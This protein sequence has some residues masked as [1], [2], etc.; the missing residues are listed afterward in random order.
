MDE[1]ACHF[2]AHNRN[3]YPLVSLPP[4][5]GCNVLTSF[6]LSA[7]NMIHGITGNRP[8]SASA[9][10]ASWSAYNNNDCELYFPSGNGT[11]ETTAM[12]RR[13]CMEWAGGKQFV[14]ALMDMTRDSFFWMWEIGPASDGVVRLALWLYQPGLQKY[15]MPR[16]SVG[17]LAVAKDSFRV[18]R[19]FSMWKTGVGTTVLMAVQSKSSGIGRP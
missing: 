10:T 19:V 7:Y 11:A 18:G 2:Q 6:R 9:T 14:L 12:A 8:A 13:E 5:I 15:F 17:V 4:G 3:A 1:G 16:D